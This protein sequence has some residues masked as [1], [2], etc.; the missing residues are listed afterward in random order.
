MT[1]IDRLKN[2]P[3]SDEKPRGFLIEG[4]ITAKGHAGDVLAK[5]RE[6]LMTALN[7]SPNS[8][9]TVDEWRLLLPSWFV[10]R[11]ADEITREEAERRRKLPMEERQRLA[12]KWSVGAWTHWMKASERS[13]FWWDAKEISPDELLIRIEV[14][15]LPSPVG[16]LKWLLLAAGAEKVAIDT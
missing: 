3:P 8:W 6:V 16:S 11:C 10:S 14:P 7:H 13:W 2:N 12:E 15:G 5:T 1:E 9:P 4:R